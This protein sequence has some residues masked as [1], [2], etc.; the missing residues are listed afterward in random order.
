MRC[1]LAALILYVAF[2]YVASPLSAATKGNFEPEYAEQL[3]WEGQFGEAAQY[4]E[5]LAREGY[6]NPV[7]LSCLV[8]ALWGYIDHARYYCDRAYTP[9][10]TM[11]MS[12][13]AEVFA[14]MAL[15]EWRAGNFEEAEKLLQR[16]LDW[17]KQPRLWLV[18][19]VSIALRTPEHQQI[20]VGSTLCNQL[21]AT[22][23]PR[24]RLAFAAIFPEHVK[25]IGEAHT[26]REVAEAQ[27]HR[28]RR[29]M[30]AVA[31]ISVVLLATA[32]AYHQRARIVAF[33]RPAP[34]AAHTQ[35]LQPQPH[36]MPAYY[37]PRY[38]NQAYRIASYCFAG[39][40]IVLAAPLV[41]ALLLPAWMLLLDFSAAGFQR[42][43]ASA[44]GILL[45]VFSYGRLWFALLLSLMG[46]ATFKL[47]GRFS[48]PRHMRPRIRVILGTVRF[49]SS[50]LSSA[51]SPPSSPT[52]PPRSPAS[53]PIRS[54][55]R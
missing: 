3:I 37:D 4:L 53:T 31:V 8:Y 43:Y 9:F 55:A 52:S 33:L 25:T 12:H 23:E 29:F 42:A 35:A 18:H 26:A 5:T 22:N 45:T 6:Y 44:T 2:P 47:Y 20:E 54:C 13:T 10:R 50:A 24:C 39:F 11:D 16:A 28:R 32:G 30:T 14:M 27:A 21:D 1:W 17:R 36:V 49:S 48:L 15:T 46:F 51:A 41:L 19:M 40:W 7:R 38:P 34:S